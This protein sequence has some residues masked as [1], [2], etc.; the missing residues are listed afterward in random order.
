[1]Y[2]IEELSTYQFDY[3]RRAELMLLGQTTTEDT[4]VM[5][6]PRWSVYHSPDVKLPSTMNSDIFNG[7]DDV[8]SIDPSA[9]YGPYTWTAMILMKDRIYQGMV[10]RITST[11][12]PSIAAIYGIRK[13]ITNTQLRVK[14]IAKEIIDRVIDSLPTEVRYLVVPSPLPPMG[15]ILRDM[16]FQEISLKSDSPTQRVHGLIRGFGE[17]ISY[18]DGWFWKDL[19]S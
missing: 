14:G 17:V 5:I 1:M 6:T 3:I 7:Y 12:H 10:W 2:R 16:S 19:R 15:P 18:T 13:S 9:A 4:D 8:F 11:D